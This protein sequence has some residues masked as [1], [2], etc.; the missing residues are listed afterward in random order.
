K[1]NY[2]LL[3]GVEGVRTVPWRTV[4]RVENAN[5]PGA[6]ASGASSALPP[7]PCCTEDVLNEEEPEH[8]ADDWAAVSIGWDL[9]A[10]GVSLFKHY[11]VDG[12]GEWYSGQG[13]GGGGSLS[14]HFRGPASLGS[15]TAVRWAEFELGVTDSIHSVT[16][17]EGAPNETEFIQNQLSLILGA[18]LASGRWG[19]AGSPWSGVVFGLAWLP[20]YTHFWG[21]S[22]FEATGKLHIAGMRATVDW[23]RVSPTSKGLVPGV[24]AS[25]TWLPYIGD[26]P[27]ALSLGLGVVF[28]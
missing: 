10:E 11:T 4:A 9:R 17:R 7:T 12:Q 22:D 2:V 26:L 14:L 25:L 21:S 20:T 24:R 19:S 15:S 13:W 6:A 1:G 3:L 27:T 28:Y 18:H 16:W 8:G 23:G 5:D